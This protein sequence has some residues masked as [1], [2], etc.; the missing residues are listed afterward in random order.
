MRFPKAALAC[1][2][3]AIMLTGCEGAS[4]RDPDK[5]QVG[6][7]LQDDS[8]WAECYK[9]CTCGCWK[10]DQQGYYPDAVLQPAHHIA[11]A[12]GY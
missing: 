9:N 4:Y 2:A 1:L 3:A 6:Q 7:C 11:P 8:N 12:S 10:K 5:C